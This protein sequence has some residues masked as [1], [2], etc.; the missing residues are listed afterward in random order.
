MEKSVSIRKQHF[1]LSPANRRRL[2]A[3]LARH[4]EDPDRVTPRLKMGDV[5]N[6]AL[7]IWLAR[8]GMPRERAHAERSQ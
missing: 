2:E 5:V 8:R 1:E 7:D 3:Y 6:R 4:N